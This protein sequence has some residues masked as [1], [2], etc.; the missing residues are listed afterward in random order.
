MKGS[1]S[2]KKILILFFILLGRTTSYSAPHPAVATSALTSPDKGLFWSR[3]G[4]LLK[5]SSLDWKAD[6]Q[7]SQPEQVTYLRN[8]PNQSSHQ[9]RSA[10]SSTSSASYIVRT[11]LLKQDMTLETYAKRWMKDYSNYGFDVLGSQSY[12]KGALKGLIIDVEHK[13]SFQQLRQVI[14][15]KNKRVALLTCADDKKMFLK[16]L[17]KCSESMK[18]FEW[19]SV[20]IKP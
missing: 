15:I 11:E 1:P 18:S 10:S 16:T 2:M 5:T 8:P 9:G 17:E 14:F 6:L 13:K 7:R 20:P 3:A 19:T 4:F 12:E